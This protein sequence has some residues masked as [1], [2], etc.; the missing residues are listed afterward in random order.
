MRRKDKKR[1]STNAHTHARTHK[2]SGAH[3]HTHS[4]SQ[5]QINVR[6]ENN[7]VC[8][9]HTHLSQTQVFEYITS[10]WEKE[11]FPNAEQDQQ[12]PTTNEKR[13][14]EEAVKIH[15]RMCI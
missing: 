7:N 14:T 9:Q 10:D 8:T 13:G 6:K 3:T 5:T 4:Q 15:I 2:Y 1:T 11:R 12:N